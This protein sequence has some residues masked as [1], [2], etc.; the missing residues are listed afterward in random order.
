GNGAAQAVEKPD[1]PLRD[2]EVA[3]LCRF[4]NPESYFRQVLFL[5]DEYQHF[6]TVGESAP[7]G[8]ENSSVCPASPNAFSSSRHRASVSS[9][10]HCR[11]NRGA[12]CCKRF[13]RKSFCRF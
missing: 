1:E 9:S 5:C 10:P 11:E 8:D 3:F 2:I 13:A 7:T 6:A 12:S 4:K